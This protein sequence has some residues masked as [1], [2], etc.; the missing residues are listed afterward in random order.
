M[1][2]LDIKI[3]NIDLIE[4]LWE[5]NRAY[6]EALSE[7]FSHEYELLCFGDRMKKF[8]AMDEN[9]YKITVCQD[10]E[11]I[12]GYCISTI[13]DGVGEVESIHVD[14]TKR[15]RGIGEALVSSHL[16]WMREIACTRIGVTVSQE[17]AA[18]I[19]FY[20]KLG[21]Y[22]NTLYMQQQRD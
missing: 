18:T 12:I 19:G 13:K 2:Y 7:Y 1:K 6:H 5:K 16:Q 20:R 4:T 8:R 3:E 17:N 9:L 22:P 14:A 21:F 15:G 10:H 11:N